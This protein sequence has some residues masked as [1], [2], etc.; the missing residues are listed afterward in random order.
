VQEAG[1]TLL[2]RRLH[3]LQLPASLAGVLPSCV[4]YGLLDDGA[5]AFI[6]EIA[7]ALQDFL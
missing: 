2:C 3:F 1:Q 7:R 4:P 6:V 5:R